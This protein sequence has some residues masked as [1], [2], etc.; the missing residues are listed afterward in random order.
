[1]ESKSRY[2][3]IA[4]LKAAKT[5]PSCVC[6]PQL[7]LADSVIFHLELFLDIYLLLLS[8]QSRVVKS[9]SVRYQWSSQL[10]GTLVI[11]LILNC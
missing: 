6:S 4:G 10:Y 11:V 3:S 5:E 9:V 8:L 2:C 1:M 7:C